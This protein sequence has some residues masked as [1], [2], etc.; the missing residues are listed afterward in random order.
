MSE[1]PKDRAVFSL[2]PSPQSVQPDDRTDTPGPPARTGNR[3]WPQ[4]LQGQLVAGLSA[5][6]IV[7]LAAL[8]VAA[9]DPWVRHGAIIALAVGSLAQ[10]ALS[11]AVCRRVDAAALQDARWRD[12]LFERAGISLWREDWT[13]VGRAI[14]ALR[15]ANVQDVRAHFAANRDQLRALRRAVIIKD[16]NAFTVQMMGAPSKAAFLG[17]LDRILPDS[18]QTFEQWMVAF[19]RGDAFYRSETHIVRPDGVHIDTLFTAALP[20]DLEGYADI[21]VTALDITD[22]KALQARL[23]VLETETARATRISTMGALTATIAHEV[24]TPL[25][26]ILANVEAAQRWLSRPEPE[27]PEARQ[28]LSRA[29]SDIARTHE[30]VSRT[31]SFLEAR[32]TSLQPVDLAET[33]QVAMV[34]VDR[35]L[36]AHNV[37]VHLD[38]EP[39][40]P[41]VAAD[42][43]QLQQVIVNLLINGVHAM[44]AAPSPRD[45]TLSL[46]TSAEGVQLT[47]ADSG[48][49]IPLDILP[50]LFEPFVS[51]KPN[52]MGLGLAICRSC[53]EALGGRISAENDPVGGGARVHVVLP[54]HRTPGE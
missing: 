9:P 40:L 12:A 50:R 30:V 35:E 16:V 13:A 45:L 28:A 44:K 38:V 19:W 41:T 4:R 25:A 52:G 15:E 22:Y 31:R 20:S 3:A 24:N 46:R 2:W 11:R 29:V 21:L 39:D 27:L 48:P 34:L 17:P 14:I 43:I 53:V 32:P 18:D 8:A 1:R 6:L 47:V 51:Q 10:M 33:A 37:A 42:S 5:G 26:A 23:A 49:G 7:A 36:R 54:V